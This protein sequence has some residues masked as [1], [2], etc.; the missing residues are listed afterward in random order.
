MMALLT[1]IMH[2]GQIKC[3]KPQ[4]NHELCIQNDELCNK[5]EGFCKPHATHNRQSPPQLNSQGIDSIII[6]C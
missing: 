1:G 5:N 2:M 6:I 3:K 4:N